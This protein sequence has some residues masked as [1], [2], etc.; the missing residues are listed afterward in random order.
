MI[1]LVYETVNL[2]LTVLTSFLDGNLLEDGGFIHA[3][4]VVAHDKCWQDDYCTVKSTDVTDQSKE[5]V[6]FSF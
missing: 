4:A 2:S 6:K 3:G 5:C 1:Q